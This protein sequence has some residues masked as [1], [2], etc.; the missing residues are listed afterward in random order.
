MD[1]GSIVVFGEALVDDFLTEQVVGGAPFNVA[2]NLA[3]FGCAPLMLTRIGDDK[4][5]AQ[6]RAE[7]VRFGLTQRGL[8]IDPQEPTGRVVV[9]R[10]DGEHRFVI[11]PAQAYDHIDGV[12]ALAALAPSSPS[13]VYFGTLVQRAAGS[14]EALHAVLD[15]TNATRYLDLNVREGQVNE[16]CVFESLHAADIVK[17]N[18]EELQD[19]FKWYTHTRHETA[20]MD[21]LGLRM[22]CASLLRIFSLEGL[23]VTLGARG[24]VYFGADGGVTVNTGIAGPTRVVD[25]V[26]AGDAFS[27]VFL[28]GRERGWPLR[29]TLARA[30][31]FAA[32]VCGVSGAV[33]ADGAFHAPYLARWCAAAVTESA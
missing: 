8:Q 14:R 25:T 24:S 12:T 5:G 28:L 31:E 3:A 29:D 4:S 15:A 30:N 17:V 33:S 2:R 22:A 6:V 1:T 7:F 21:N 10:A 19:L 11:L 13:I 26:G 20:D 32:A 9:E 18:E 27:A 23:I 16:R